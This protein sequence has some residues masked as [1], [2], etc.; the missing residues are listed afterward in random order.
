MAIDDTKRQARRERLAQWRERKKAKTSNADGLKKRIVLEN[1]GGT[2]GSTQTEDQLT[3]NNRNDIFKNQ[4]EDPLDAFMSFVDSEGY[5]SVG[6]GVGAGKVIAKDNLDDDM[7]ITM[8][9][10]EQKKK[11]KRKEI[12]KVNHSKIAYPAFR[13]EVWSRVFS[14]WSDLGLPRPIMEVLEE[15]GIDHPTDVQLHAIPKLM[16]GEDCMVIAPTGSGKTLAFGLPALRHVAANR[17]CALIM[18][19][20]RELGTQIG[21][22]LTPYARSWDTE[23]L[24][25]CGGSDIKP[26]I[27]ASRRQWQILVATPGRLID[28]LAVNGGR[29]FNLHRITMLVIDEADRMLDMGFGPQVTRISNS[30]RPDR[31]VALFSATASPKMAEISSKLFSRDPVEVSV[32]SVS[33][34]PASVK[35][36][37][38]II[39]PEDK[40]QR[41]LEL[42]NGHVQVLVF[43]ESQQ[44]ADQLSLQLKARGYR[45]LSLHGGQSQADRDSALNEFRSGVL[46]L[47]VA[48]SVAA[49][50]LDVP[51]LSLVVNYDAPDHFE[52][53]VHRAGRTGRAG[54]QGTAV[55]FITRDQP[56]QAAD[57]KTALELAH[58]DVSPDLAELA[59]KAD[60]RRYGFGGKGLGRLAAER[61]AQRAVEKDAFLSDDSEHDSSSAASEEED[62]LPDP[63][64]EENK[65]R[66]STVLI[67]N[68]YPQPARLA[69]VAAGNQ[70]AVIERHRVSITGRGTFNNKT[71]KL[72]LIIEGDSKEE[73]NRAYEEL[74]ELLLQGAARRRKY[75]V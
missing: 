41:L 9:P 45:S 20:T 42:I 6:V 49:R 52:D 17:S 1:A 31:Q 56:A 19:P 47:L 7:D 28:L 8:G 69:V 53:Y 33:T 34:V 25:C 60:R 71:D 12:P 39:N 50:G 43:T 3:V 10:V 73:V 23:L 37:V 64:I 29:I 54:N 4:E 57:A 59:A 38:E 44:R 35:Q 11:A 22:A 51:R 72:R 16:S 15:G 55:T 27:A 68:D 74:G 32:G 46:P 65:G 18:A 5:K 75:V 2:H 24:V 26:Q 36:Q 67:I 48:T 21:D 63:K 66:F 14:E 30:I 58:N 70:A 13:R 40:L 62:R 61:R